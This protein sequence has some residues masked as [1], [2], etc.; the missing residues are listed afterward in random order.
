MRN[1]R[2]RS[3]G[4]PAIMIIES[5]RL[6]QSTFV[7]WQGARPAVMP[8]L[9]WLHCRATFHKNLYGFRLVNGPPILPAEQR[10]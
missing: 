6:C 10:S 4:R 8:K 1:L 7:V 3:P 5:M 2:S 9:L